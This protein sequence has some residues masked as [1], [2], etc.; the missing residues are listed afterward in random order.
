MLDHTEYNIFQRF[1]LRT[2]GTVEIKGKIIVYANQYKNRN[3]KIKNAKSYNYSF[4][5]SSFVY[6]F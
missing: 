3:Q 2:T 1:I 4:E 6:Y 5:Y